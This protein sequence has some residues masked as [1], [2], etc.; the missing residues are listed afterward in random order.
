MNASVPDLPTPPTAPV[1][2]RHFLQITRDLTRLIE[3]ESD[4]LKRKRPSDLG[5]FEAE[6]RRLSTAYTKAVAALRVNKD[7]L[8][9]MTAE[10]KRA[11]KEAI[12]T[13]EAALK[14]HARLVLRLKTVSEGMV[15][16]VGREVEKRSRPVSSYQGNAQ[17]R[18]P[19]PAAAPTSISLDQHA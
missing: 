19:A 6:K 3:Q 14:A 9:A 2:V 12:E 11:L 4:L 13:F 17:M 5:A 16:A 18:P 8:D 10:D 15:R 7:A 1:G